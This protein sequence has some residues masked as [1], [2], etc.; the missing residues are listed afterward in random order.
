M[1]TDGLPQSIIQNLRQ[2][3]RNQR[4]QVAMNKHATDARTIKASTILYYLLLRACILTTCLLRK[5]LTMAKLTDR[6][7]YMQIQLSLLPAS[8]R[9][10]N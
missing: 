2:S 4:L 6:T 9:F 7:P 3:P 5:H 10:P 1:I 8:S